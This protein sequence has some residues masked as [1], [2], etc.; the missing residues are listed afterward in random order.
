MKQFVKKHGTYLRIAALVLLLL[1]GVALLLTRCV[2]LDRTAVRTGT[3]F[4][5]RGQTYTAYW[6]TS[7]NSDRTLAKTEDG[8]RILAVKGDPEHRFLVLSSFLDS[9]LCVRE[10][11]EIPMD[12][13]LNGVYWQINRKITDPDFLSAVDDILNNFRSDYQHETS[14]IFTHT[15]T[16]QLS[17]ISFCFEDCPVGIDAHDSYMGMMDGAWVFARRAAQRDDTKD[18]TVYVYDIYRIPEEHHA[19]LRTFWLD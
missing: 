13:V 9:E 5:W 7:Y 1:T 18:E 10:D 17:P 8:F 6:S 15:D 3:G 14:A 19:I 11:Y 2:L 4:T 16:R 12:G